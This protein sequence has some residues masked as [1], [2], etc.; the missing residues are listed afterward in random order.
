[1]ALKQEKKE[2]EFL[3]LYRKTFKK[4]SISSPFPSFF[5]F[6]LKLSVVSIFMIRSRSNRQILSTISAALHP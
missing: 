4:P 1:M 6:F 3:I 5:F 2:V